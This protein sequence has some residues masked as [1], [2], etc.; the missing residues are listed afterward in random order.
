MYHSISRDP[1][2]GVASYYRL[3]TSPNVFRQQMSWLHERGYR[4]V[5]AAGLDPLALG[6]LPRD[7]FVVITFDD[8]FRDNLEE[9]LP[10]LEQFGFSATVYLATAYIRDKRRSFRGR[11]CLTWSEVREMQ[12]R[13]VRFG[14]HTVNHPVLHEL[15]WRDIEAEIRDS[16]S[17]LEDHIQTEV[18]SFAYPYAFPQEDSTYVA[19]LREMLQSAPY[20]DCMTTMI[21]RPTLEDDPYLLKRL[22]VNSDDDPLSFKAK[23]EGA[24]DWMGCV[25][26]GVRRLKGLCRRRITSCSETRGAS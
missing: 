18:T 25:Q 10:V 19:R 26:T 5:N 23:V 17:L 12:A 8:G 21:G 9:A 14:S 22:A 3:C 11:D 16:K 7:P 1:E 6:S 20:R 4:T 15:G 24:Y 13:G 2:R